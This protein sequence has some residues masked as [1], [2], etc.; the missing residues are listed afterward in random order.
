MTQGM[1]VLP[2]A[3]P[4]NGPGI[5]VHDRPPT[6]RHQAEHQA[7]GGSER[8]NEPQLGKKDELRGLPGGII[9]KGSRP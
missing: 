8:Q 4:S 9:A 6:F 1:G 5:R 2:P 3:P 7:D